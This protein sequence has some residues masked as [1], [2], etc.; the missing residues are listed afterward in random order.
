MSEKSPFVL[1]HGA[2]HGAWCW[3]RLIPLLEAA[4]HP[5]IATSCRGVGERAAEL[6]ADVG[7]DSYVSD[8]TSAIEAAELTDVV[9]VGHSH[10]GWVVAG[11]ADRIPG[12]IGQFVF[13]DANLVGAGTSQFSTL[14]PD[15][16]MA[17]RTAAAQSPGGLS[18]PA[19]PA[20]AFGITSEADI[21]WVESH[22]SP[23]PLKT[24]E[25]VLR[26]EHPLG[27]GLPKTY[28]ACVNPAFSAVASAH[29]W[30]REQSDWR[31]IEIA[32]GHDA[33]VIAPALLAQTLLGI[34]GG[35][36]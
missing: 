14:D 21:A 36:E 17:R 27:N 10:G 16:V 13:L 6:T 34:A 28:V 11:V 15:L 12:R 5:A 24:Y 7:L 31:Y 19:P 26:L 18:M 2:W 20:S 35:A 8:V 3:Q 22:L 1:V 29:R 23:Q 30:A 4:G 25:D 32:T 33:M 9:L